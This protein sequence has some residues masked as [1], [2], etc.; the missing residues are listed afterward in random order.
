MSPRSYSFFPLFLH[1]F[2]FILN[3]YCFHLSLKLQFK[4]VKDASWPL[5]SCVTRDSGWGTSL[6]FTEGVKAYSINIDIHTSCLAG[7]PDCPPTT[8]VT[9]LCR[10]CPESGRGIAWLRPPPALS[11]WPVC[12]Q[13][14]GSHS[15]W[16][17][18]SPRQMYI[19]SNTLTLAV[20]GDDKLDSLDFYTRH[21]SLQMNT[22]VSHSGFQAIHIARFKSNIS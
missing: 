3:T 9:G 20:F 15:D 21:V 13:R 18:P 16:C 11:V 4:M 2:N 6:W 22:C 14:Q 7:S 12:Q 10:V 1:R 8:P 5:P 17:K 19:L